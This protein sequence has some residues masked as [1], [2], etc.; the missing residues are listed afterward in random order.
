MFLLMKIDIVE[1][2]LQRNIWGKS[3]LEQNPHFS[4]NL[5]RVMFLLMGLVHLASGLEQTVRPS[6]VQQ[7]MTIEATL[8]AV[9][10]EVLILM[11]EEGLGMHGKVFLIGLHHYPMGLC[12][13]H[14][15]L[16]GHI[17]VAFHLCCHSSLLCLES[18]RL[19]K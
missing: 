12:P 7:G 3:I 8:A 14:M 18:G 4:I 16:L 10:G 15:D 6:L 13:S 11:W 1:I 19:W 5:A 17:M 9:T 2:F